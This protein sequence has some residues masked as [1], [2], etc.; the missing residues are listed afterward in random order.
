M[1]TVFLH[2]QKLANMILAWF[3]FGI[4]LNL[5][6]STHR[7]FVFLRKQSIYFTCNGKNDN[8]YAEE[9]AEVF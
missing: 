5:M 6:R 7:S 2:N 1:E 8:E 9:N 3:S 4:E